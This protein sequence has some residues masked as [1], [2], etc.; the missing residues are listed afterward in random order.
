MI[1]SIDKLEKLGIYNT[2]S[3]KTASD[4]NRYNLLYGWNGSGI[5]E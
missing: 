4:F 3:S 5:K 1:P 2:I